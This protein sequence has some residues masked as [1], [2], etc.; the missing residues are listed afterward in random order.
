VNLRSTAGTFKLKYCVDSDQ[1]GS[2]QDG[3]FATRCGAFALDNVSVTGG[4]IT[5]TTG[6]ETGADGFVLS[7][8]I[9][10]SG[11]DWSNIVHINDLPPPMVN[12]VC[13]LQDS[14]LVFNDITQGGA[15]NYYQNSF[16]ASPWIDLKAYGAVGTTGKIIKANMYA[17]LPLLNYILTQFNAQ[18]YPEKCLQT[19][20]LITSPWTS[21]GFCCGYG[22][23]PSQ[24][25]QPGTLGNQIDFSGSVPAGAEQVRIAGRDLERNS[26]HVLQPLQVA[27]HEHHGHR[28]LADRGGDLGLDREDV[29]RGAIVALAPQA[30]ICWRVNQ[31]C[32]DAYPIA[33]SSDR[34]FDDRLNAQLFG[35]L[36]NRLSGSLER[37]D[38]GSR[39]QPRN[40]GPA[41]VSARAGRLDSVEVRGGGFDVGL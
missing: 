11:G 39:R 27:V 18:W 40:F 30:S 12:C 2:D 14:V 10:N 29:C 9:P 41:A 3:T 17:D 21:Y 13:N 5:Y 22:F 34:A 36:S 19:G 4:G 38:A 37:H 32:G 8:P 15:H 23:N 35:D 20:K 25:T 6:F 31:P 28:A 24:C 26:A 33:G 1:S 7:A 16:A